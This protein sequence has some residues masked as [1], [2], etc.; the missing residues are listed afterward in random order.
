[1]IDY[2]LINLRD[3]LNAYEKDS[4]TAILSDFTALTTKML[5]IS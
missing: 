1:M 3:L 2:T 4:V 5:K